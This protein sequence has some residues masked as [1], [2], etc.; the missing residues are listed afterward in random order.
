MR[1]AVVSL[2]LGALLVVGVGAVNA[3]VSQKGNLRVAVSAKIMPS[4]LPRTRTA[5]IAVTVSSEI[6]TTDGKQP[7][8]LRSI[9]LTLN[10]NGKIDYTG[11]P[12]CNFSEIE[13]ATTEEAISSCGRALVGDGT[14]SAHVA[15]PEQSPFPSKGKIVAFNGKERGKPVIYAHI[16]GTEPLPQS[17]VIVFHLKNGGKGATKLVANLPLAGAS[18]GSVTGISLTLQRRFTYRQQQR[19]YLSAGCPAPGGFPGT[20]FELAHVL[21]GFQD[22]RNLNSTVT[23]SCTVRN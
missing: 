5:P 17:S 23:R 22:G 8:Q 4:K 9:D 6:K 10:R 18:W 1:A 3:E 16:Y 2:A 13:P 15:L 7:P 21:L 19:S 14:F 11:L 12:V 20:T